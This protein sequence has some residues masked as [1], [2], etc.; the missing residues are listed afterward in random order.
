MRTGGLGPVIEGEQALICAR[1]EG[2]SN[3][4]S[5][6]HEDT[7]AGSPAD[8]CAVVSSGGHRLAQARGGFRMIWNEINLNVRVALGV[9]D[10]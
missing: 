8:I 5:R 6:A 9:F 3:Y 1:G 4:H 7:G 10:M 2:L